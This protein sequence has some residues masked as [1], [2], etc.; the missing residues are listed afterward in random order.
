MQGR[1]KAL[2]ENSQ[3]LDFVRIICELCPSCSLFTTACLRKGFFLCHGHPTQATYRSTLVNP[4]PTTNSTALVDIIQH[5]VSTSPSLIVDDLLVRVNSNCSTTITSLDVQECKS[6]IG[7]DPEV[8]R[9]MSQI[10]SVCAVRE[11]GEAICP[12]WIR[13]NLCV[14][15]VCMRHASPQ[16]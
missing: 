8:N 11:L 10:L 3:K 9:R 1:K 6:G 15:N 7:S 4:F 13:N 12:L 2:I 5:W 16:L 14:S